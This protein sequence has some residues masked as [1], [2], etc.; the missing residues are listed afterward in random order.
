LRANVEL[1]AILKQFEQK[2]GYRR[3]WRP[4]K[5]Y[6]L[7]TAGQLLASDNILLF[8]S[9][10]WLTYCLAQRTMLPKTGMKTIA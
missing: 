2:D 6:F 10:F 1:G 8:Y 5:D 3:P 4:D 9:F 7:L